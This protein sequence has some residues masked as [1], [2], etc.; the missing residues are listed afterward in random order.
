MSV[1]VEVNAGQEY[2]DETLAEW[3]GRPV[4]RRFMSKP[5]TEGNDVVANSIV[6]GNGKMVGGLAF[7]EDLPVGFPFFILQAV[8]SSGRAA[9]LFR[10]TIV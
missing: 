8:V 7:F 2:I 1:L 6:N 5:V 9:A 4:L 10:R 3:K